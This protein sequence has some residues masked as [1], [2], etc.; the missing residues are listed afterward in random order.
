MLM[1]INRIFDMENYPLSL[2][3]LTPQS[4]DTAECQQ[5]TYASYAKQVVEIPDELGEGLNYLLEI[6]PDIKLMFTDTHFHNPV[7]FESNNSEMCGATIVLEGQFSLSTENAYRN[8]AVRQNQAVLFIMGETRCQFSYPAGKIRMVNFTVSKEMMAQLGCNKETFPIENHEGKHEIARDILWAMPIFP[9]LS[10]NVQQIY[11]CNL[12]NNAHHLYISGKVMEILALLYHYHHEREK[13]YPD[14]KAHD[15]R[16]IINAAE[17]V[18]R[19]M[20]SPPSLSQLARKVGINDNKLKKLFKVVFKNTVYG[21]LKE[22]RMQRAS[23]LLINGDMSVQEVA[24]SVGF[25]HVGYFSRLFRETYDA[26]PL[27]FKRSHRNLSQS[28]PNHY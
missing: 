13:T 5:T 16:C 2:D 21:Y 19:N 18:E 26:S 11:E 6:S 8:Y 10:R 25:K 15:L 27:A 7:S 17:I 9:E 24:Q 28:V 14:I 12:N 20:I 3:H 1:I 23:E 4:M 22:K